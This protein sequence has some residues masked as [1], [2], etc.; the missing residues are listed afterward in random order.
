MR[1]AE[2]GA[3]AHKRRAPARKRALDIPVIRIEDGSISEFV[4]EEE[5]ERR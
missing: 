4:L 1:S 5:T 2:S 3:A